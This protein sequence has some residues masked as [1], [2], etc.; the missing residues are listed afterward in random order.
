MVKPLIIT[1][2]KL[3]TPGVQKIDFYH[4]QEYMGYIQDLTM[5]GVEIVTLPMSNFY[6]THEVAII[7][8]MLQK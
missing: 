7:F 4:G 1:T 2:L 5:K 6:K 3:Q 8:K